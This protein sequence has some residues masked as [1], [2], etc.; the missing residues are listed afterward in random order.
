MKKLFSLIQ[1]HFI[2]SCLHTLSNCRPSQKVFTFPS[3][4]FKVSGVTL[5]SFTQ[6]EFIFI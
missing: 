3:G 2:N 6:F 4:N 5:R 1:S